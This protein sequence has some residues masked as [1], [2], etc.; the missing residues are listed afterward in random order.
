MKTEFDITGL[1]YK[2]KDYKFR[3]YLDIKR[4]DSNQKMPDLM[5]VMMNPGSSYPLNGEEN[6]LIPTPTKPDN[7]QHQ[8]MKVMNVASFNYARIL[9]LSDLRTPDSKE[10]YAFI[11]S[12]QSDKVEHSIFA[13]C[14]ED[15]F[16]ELFVR[17][18]PVIFGWGVSEALV[19]LAKQAVEAIGIKNPLGELKVGTE[20][21]YY[22]PLP[23]NF[24][25]QQKWVQYVLNQI[26]RKYEGTR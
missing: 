10:L 22:H 19:P 18:V 1:F 8:I 13:H 25:E 23:R 24:N 21:S 16:G 3:K 14:R 12:D 2:N 20:N 9:N 5:V 17:N 26:T 7:T 6:G 11:K 15:E 4:K